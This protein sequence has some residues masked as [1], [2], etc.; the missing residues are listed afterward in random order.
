MR[1]LNYSCVQTHV[2]NRFS[3]RRYSDTHAGAEVDVEE[4]EEE[5]VVD[6]EAPLVLEPAGA[7]DVAA[8]VERVTPTASQVC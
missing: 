6:A 7:V 5:P 8:G 2:N 3:D 1:R 4:A